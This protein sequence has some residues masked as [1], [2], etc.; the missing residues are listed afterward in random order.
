[1][2][3]TLKFV[4]TQNTGICQHRRLRKCLLVNVRRGGSGSS[5]SESSEDED[6]YNQSD[7]PNT[8]T[9]EMSERLENEDVA[10]LELNDPG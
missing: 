3:Q 7:D 9:G 6:D 2:E 4:P 10:D 8:A 1:M 5:L